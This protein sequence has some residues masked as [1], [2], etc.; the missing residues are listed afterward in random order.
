LISKYDGKKL[1]STA[2]DCAIFNRILLDYRIG[3]ILPYVLHGPVLDVGCGY[4]EISEAIANLGMIVHGIDPDEEKIKNTPTIDGRTFECA[5]LEQWNTDHRYSTIVCS[6]VFEH[7]EDEFRF[8]HA[9]Y[10][11]LVLG[12]RIIVT[13]PN[14]LS[15]HKRLG[16]IMGLS[17]PYKIGASDMLDNHK[18]TLDRDILRSVMRSAGLDVIVEKG[19]MLKPFASAQM[20]KYLDSRW[21]D[22][23]YEIGKNEDLIDYCSSLLMVGEKP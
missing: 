17:E 20:A 16:D 22:A 9:C 15:L 21:H 23:F 5:N 6:H 14:A 4:G 13:V 19:I 18:R 10:E 1:T 8:V 7:V 3:E 12:G 2:E 11:L